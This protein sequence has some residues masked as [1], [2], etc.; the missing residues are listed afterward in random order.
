M[1]RTYAKQVADPLYGTIGLTQLEVEVIGTPVFQRLTNVNQLGIVHLVFPGAQYTRFAHSIGV[2]HVAGKILD[3]IAASGYDLSDDEWQRYRLAAL[4]HDVGHYPFSHTFE[5]A[6]QERNVNTHEHETVG[7]L[8]VEEDHALSDVIGS[9]FSN[10]SSIPA[11]F[12]HSSLQNIDT[13]LKDIVTSGLDADRL[14]Y[15]RRTAHATGVPYGS[16]DG[17]YLISQFEADDDGTVMLSHRAR[18]TADHFLLSRW[19]E[20]QQVIYHHTVQAADTILEDVLAAL[21][22]NDD[23]FRCTAQDVLDKITSGSWASF[24]DAMAIEGIRTLK[25]S[26]EDEILQEKCRAILERRLPKTIF[27]HS[28]FRD[29]QQ[30]EAKPPDTP[31]KEDAVERLADDFNLHSDRLYLK[32]K[33]SPFTQIWPQNKRK[34]PGKHDVRVAR[35][36]HSTNADPSARLIADDPQ[37]LMSMLSFKER[38]TWRL[39]ALFPLDWSDQ[40]VSDTRAAMRTRLLNEYL[41]DEEKEYI[42]AA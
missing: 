40:K 31:L 41:T 33:G 22:E 32:P 18:L 12:D 30:G 21:I 2:C 14:D 5:H 17:D 37:A 28:R 35:S 34:R 24:D 23:R 38:Y 11:I 26:T 13:R 29:R 36:R 16:V 4:L 3:S 1:G 19:F 20:Y 6:L 15:L 39:F 7:R 27:E 42:E 8:V 9:K 25:R 10:P